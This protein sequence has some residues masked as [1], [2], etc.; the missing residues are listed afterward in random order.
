MALAL[1]EV[2]DAERRHLVAR[3]LWN[4]PRRPRSA[5]GKRWARARRL[6]GLDP[7]AELARREKDLA[8]EQATLTLLE[9]GTRPDEIEAARACLLRLHE[10]AQYLEGLAVKQVVS[11]SISG[12]VVTSH[13]KDKIGQYL[14]EGDLICVIEEPAVLEAE[15]A[16]AEQEVMYVQPGQR[17]EL[18][19]RALPFETL[20]GRVDRLAPRAGLGDTS[21][22]SVDRPP[23]KVPPGETQGFVTVY[24]RLEYPTPELRPGMTGHARIY[25]GRRTLGEVAAERAL[26]Q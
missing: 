1:D 13:L 11:S 2:Q 17:V 21:Q 20:Q 19:V 18:K 8:D 3:A 14:K 24:C 9:A 26:R 10:E 4:R 7:E 23:A 6:P 5:S 12:V 15:I 22:P 25:R 16:V